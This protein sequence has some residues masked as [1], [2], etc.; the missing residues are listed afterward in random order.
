MVKNVRAYAIPHPF[1][2][3][4]QSLDVKHLCIQR[5][6]GLGGRNVDVVEDLS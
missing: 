3:Y 6:T 2:I 4:L 5:V 1:L